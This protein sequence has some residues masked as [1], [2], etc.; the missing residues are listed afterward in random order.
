MDSQ[1]GGSVGGG[2][3]RLGTQS[4]HGFS[5]AG[6][7]A[8]VLT[9]GMNAL[10]FP[11]TT[12]LPNNWFGRT[13]G[14]EGANGN[15]GGVG[16]DQLGLGGQTAAAPGDTAVGVGGDAEAGEPGEAA[17]DD[18]AAGGE[19]DG[20]DGEDQS[21]DED[22]DGDD[23][24][25]S[26][27][28]EGG[29]AGETDDGGD[30]GDGSG[31]DDGDEAQ[32]GDDGGDD[33]D[34]SGG[35]DGNGSGGGDDGGDG[36]S[37]G[38]DGGF[39]GG[40]G[41]SSGG[42]GAGG[43]GGAGVTPGAPPI[44]AQPLGPPL[45]PPVGSTLSGMVTRGSFAAPGALTLPANLAK[46]GGV[47]F[48]D[49]AAVLTE[50]DQIEGA[51]WDSGKGLLVLVGRQREQDEAF[52]MSLPRMDQD[53][54]IV[55]LRA[56][57]SGQ[58]AGVS[59]DPPS[60]YRDG[61]RRGVMPPDGTP[62]L[63][64]YLGGTEGTLF[65]A[66]MFEADRLLKCMSNDRDNVT[67]E[68]LEVA[69]PGFKSFLEGIPVDDSA[70]QNQWHRFWFVIDLVELRYNSETGAAAFGDVRIKVLDEAEVDGQPAVD[71]LDPAARDFAVHLTDHYDD[72][73]R[74]FPVLGRLKELAKVAALAKFLASEMKTLDLAKIF[75]TEPQRVD[76]PSST[77]A[78]H[79]TSPN[80]KVRQEGDHTVTVT[81][82]LCGGIDMDASPDVRQ[83]DGTA[84]ELKAVAESARPSSSVAGWVLE[85][86]GE[87]FR[88]KAVRIG[89]AAS[90]VRRV[91]ADHEPT[92]ADAAGLLRIRRLYDSACQRKGDF[93]PG[94]ALWIPFSLEMVSRSGKRPEVLT[95]REAQG[96]SA[97]PVLLLYEVEKFEMHLYRRTD[98][99]ENGEEVF[100]KLT[101]QTLEQSGLSFQYNPAE[102]I[103]A[104]SGGYLMRRGGMEYLFDPDGNLSK[105]SRDGCLLVHYRRREG[106]LVRI[107][108]GHRYYEIGYD[109][110]EPGRISR[111]VASDGSEMRYLYDEAGCLLRCEGRRGRDECYAYDNRGRLV[112]VRSDNNEIVA[113]NVYDDFGNRLS[114]SADCVMTEAGERVSRRL[115]SGRVVSATD[116][117]GTTA[118]FEYG[119]AGEL[120]SLEIKG[121]SGLT[122]RLT[123]DT[124]G[125]FTGLRNARHTAW[126]FEY[127][128]SGKL[129]RAV[130]PSGRG[131]V[132]GW[133]KGDRLDRITDEQGRSW[134]C[135]YDGSGR[136]RKILTQA[137]EQWLFRYVRGALRAASRGIGKV[138]V[139]RKSDTFTSRTDRR[140]GTWRKSVFD[141]GLRLLACRE[142][143]GGAVRLEYDNLGNVSRVH[144]EAG[145]LEYHL[146]EN[147]LTLTV[148]FS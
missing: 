12:L 137:G 125:R 147:E 55:A 144:N 136:L 27:D 70:S 86:G 121:V 38:G 2:T 95:R 98:I 73:A 7:A 61:M 54:L 91:C 131:R 103:E 20:D 34:G 6:A 142:R 8:E 68:T 83:D 30:D 45:A 77:P 25:G 143:R 81:R 82:S 109:R 122:W 146:D 42:S 9:S 52:A 115:E 15:G 67:R 32:E 102:R 10:N 57:L 22:R 4:A 140:G 130:G 39:D 114:E 65:G 49:C 141:T 101:G 26:G 23:G 28:G 19:D 3:L 112:E 21:Q 104:T 105:V 63:V 11:M 106:R 97:P 113:R 116:E 31:D 110:T 35:D 78:I 84:T 56:Y 100:C 134:A 43:S 69:V 148:G 29:E 118:V 14:K 128:G 90:P 47:L 132:Y 87:K 71:D 72:Y 94:W 41:R 79:V 48:D 13:P 107:T 88:A 120:R 80:V 135:E 117:S 44:A 111:I 50:V 51:Y 89:A 18:G 60:E 108:S 119:K 58:A 123:Y 138:R 5:G 139:W 37:N 36:G 145:T 66:I 16:A 17:N 99:K 96:R 85:Q 127:K 75:T 126:R 46:P 124:N 129:R 24:D 59:I 74:A 62:F 133:R 33:G 76:T 1:V 92:L 40:D 53:H 93:G 64:S